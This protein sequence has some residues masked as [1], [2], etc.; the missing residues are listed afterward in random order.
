LVPLEEFAC[1]T[2]RRFCPTAAADEGRNLDDYLADAHRLAE[3]GGLAAKPGEPPPVVRRE[4]ASWPQ[5]IPVAECLERIVRDQRYPLVRRLVHGLAVCDDLDRCHLQ[6]LSA[7]QLGEILT[8]LETS[9]ISE[10]ATPWSPRPP[11]RA[12]AMLFRQTALEYLRLHPNF[13]IERSWRER[14]RLMRTAMAFARGRGPLPAMHVCFP[15]TTFEALQRPL[16]ALEAAVERPLEA[17]FEATAASKRYALPDRP[18]WSLVDSFRDLA[19]T[20]PLALWLLRLTCGDRLPEVG[21]M[22]DVVGA[23]DRWLSYSSLNTRRHHRRIRSLARLQELARLVA[24]YA[25]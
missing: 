20:Y 12:A 16:S 19:M 4:P 22:I 9:A 21:D 11:S 5:V 24:W 2:L 7:D 8:M 23:T 3:Q 1:L 18:G 13:V 14:W 10:A 6:N 17:F 15:P 25:R